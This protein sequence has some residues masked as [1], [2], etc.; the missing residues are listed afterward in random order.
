MYS[1]KRERERGHQLPVPMGELKY[2]YTQT[3]IA[4]TESRRRLHHYK[5]QEEEEKKMYR[6]RIEKLNTHNTI[7]SFRCRATDLRQISTWARKWNTHTQ[8]NTYQKKSRQNDTN[9]C[10]SCSSVLILLSNTNHSMHALVFSPASPHFVDIN[11]N[12]FCCH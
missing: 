6:T 12:L 3:N 2:V 4:R 5:L 8:Q 1:S 7:N 11:N 10:Y 9:S